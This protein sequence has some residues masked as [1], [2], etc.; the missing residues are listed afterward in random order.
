LNLAAKRFERRL[1]EEVSRLRLEFHD[2]LAGVRVELHEQLATTRVETFKWSFLFWIGQVAA[3]G[4]LLAYM[5]RGVA[6]I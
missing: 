1:I 3:T 6:R 4:L 5:L 2:G